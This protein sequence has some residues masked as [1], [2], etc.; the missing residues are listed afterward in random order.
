MKMEERLDRLERENRRLKRAGALV[1]ALAVSIL[2]MGAA[3][4]EK[5]KKI[6]AEEIV[7]KDAAGKTRIWLSVTRLGPA[8]HLFDE[9]GVPRAVLMA[10]SLQFTDGDVTPRLRLALEKGAPV[11]LLSDANDRA[12]AVLGVGTKGPRLLFT[13]PSGEVLWK[14]P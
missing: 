1:A 7:L 13:K 3:A 8:L 9:K 2:A 10:Q 11:V 4:P 6:E 14:A 12:R 5:G